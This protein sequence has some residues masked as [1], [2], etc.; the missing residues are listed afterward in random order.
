[1]KKEKKIK[2]KRVRTLKKGGKKKNDKK[3]KKTKKQ[4]CSPNPDKNKH[5]FTC[6]TSEALFKMRN[7]WNARHPDDTIDSKDPK[8]IWEGLKRKLVS[9]CDSEMCWM[10]QNFMKNGLSEEMRYFTFAPKAPSSWKSN[11]KTWLTSTDIAAV[12]K[13]FENTYPSCTILVMMDLHP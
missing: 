13:Q 7:L 9:V 3:I 2:L 12:M 6:Y 4:R 5:D 1:M 11:P 10:N 8:A